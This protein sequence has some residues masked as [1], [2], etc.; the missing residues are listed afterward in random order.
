MNG[1]RLH[2]IRQLWDEYRRLVEDGPRDPQKPWQALDTD[3]LFVL[4]FQL[5]ESVGELLAHI[6]KH[7]GS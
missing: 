6:K 4:S 5:R 2:H 7:E 1:D 3:R